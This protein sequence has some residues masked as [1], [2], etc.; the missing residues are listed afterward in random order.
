MKKEISELIVKI[1]EYINSINQEQ[2]SEKR[3]FSLINLPRRLSGADKSVK[4]FSDHNINNIDEYLNGMEKSRTQPEYVIEKLP[5]RGFAHQDGQPN[6]VKFYTHARIAPDVWSTF[7]S[8][9]HKASEDTTLKIVIGLRLSESEADEFLAL[10]GVAFNFSDD[11]HKIIL[12]C[13]NNNIYDPDEVYE[14]LEYYIE[15]LNPKI[16]NIYAV[17][18]PRRDC[19]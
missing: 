11:T 1:E 18:K 16:R 5:E 2:D 9:K 17:K 12:A 13:I 10:G 3:T 19:K 15:H 7:I 4:R 14:V 6:Y 8:G